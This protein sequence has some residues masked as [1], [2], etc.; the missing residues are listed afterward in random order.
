MRIT[1][2]AGAFW[3]VLAAARALSAGNAGG[4]PA[5]GAPGDAAQ[6]GSPVEVTVRGLKPSRDIGAQDM[7]ASTLRDVPGTFGD[8]FQSVASLPGVGPMA[9][10][11]SY[12]YARG[13][14]PADTGYFLDGIPLPTLFHIGPGPSVVPPALLARV[15]FFPAA[16]PARFGRFAGGIIAG[17]SALPSPHARGEASWRLFDASALVESPV[18]SDSSVLL[19]GRY[20]YPNLLLKFFAPLLSLS[21]GDYTFR[22]THKLT[23]SDD[24]SL[25]AIGAYDTEKD[26]SGQLLPVD[27]RFQRV[28]LRYD[29][30]WRDGRLRLAT[31][32]GDD[33]TAARTFGLLSTPFAGSS[34][35]LTETSVRVRFEVGQRLSAVSRLSAGADANGLVDHS[36]SA[37]V[38]NAQQMAGAF[39]DLE[40]RPSDRVAII[41][42]GRVDAYASPGGVTGSVDPRLAVRIRVAPNVTSITTVGVA[43]Q[44]PTYLL[45]VPGLR[46]DPA[47]GLQA[48]YQ[49]AQGAEVRLPWALSATLTAFYNADPGMNDFVSDCG[50]FAINCNVVARVDGATYGLEVI[51]QRAFSQKLA[52]WLSYTLL[53]AERHIGGIPFL[54]PFDRTNVLSAVVRYDFGHGID[55]GVRATYNTGRPEIPSILL[56]GQSLAT[57]FGATGVVQHRLPHFF[58]ID[59]RAA[60][61]WNLAEGRWL[62]A[63]LEFFNATMNREAVDFRCSIVEWRCTAERVGPIALPSIGLEGGF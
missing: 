4:N 38:P 59:A 29:H 55:A 10:G 30:R 11:L 19:A 5:G 7:P 1:A 54:S 15:E 12:F 51:V 36:G 34:D 57:A 26:E 21:Y 62:S 39:L 22:L 42:G 63:V 44:P 48:A 56:E 24:I 46:L 23:D 3:T 20:G 8:P 6:D 43:H 14:P 18:G 13:A 50:A 16:A 52:G 47:D 40:V 61:R 37:T 35:A 2:V 58:R 32:F 28:D 45:P 17:E 41:A 53:R 49:Y 60:K 33:R 25:F 31:T 27:T 9:S